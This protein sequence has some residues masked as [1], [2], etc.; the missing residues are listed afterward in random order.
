MSIEFY[1]IGCHRPIVLSSQLSE[2]DKIFRN[3]MSLNMSIQY[4]L[5]RRINIDNSHCSGKSL[6][7]LSRNS[8]KK[9]NVKIR[10][11]KCPWKSQRTMT[12]RRKNPILNWYKKEEDSLT[13]DMDNFF[14][15]K[16]SIPF[17]LN[18]AINIMT[19]PK[20][21]CSCRTKSILLLL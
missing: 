9:E 6:S 3:K 16:S 11:K 12:S 8:N 15:M 19:Q 13:T 5:P 10:N 2:V 1:Y 14:K 4:S 17:L 7:V 20:L 18:P 21:L